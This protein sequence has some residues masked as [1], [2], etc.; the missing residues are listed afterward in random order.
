MNKDASITCVFGF[1][2]AGKTTYIKNEVKGCNALVVFD[3]VEEYAEPGKRGGV[4]QV[5]AREF[6]PTLRR[7]KTRN[8]RLAFTPKPGFERDNLDTLC[9]ILMQF[10][11]GYK[12]GIDKRQ[13]TL[14]VDEADV[15]YSHSTPA[16]HAFETVI[17]R[18]RHYGINVIAATQFPTQVKPDLRRNA[19]RTVI[20]PLSD[21]SAV[22]YVCQ[23]L[24]REY[25]DKV[26][27]LQP[28]HALIFEAGQVRNHKNPPPK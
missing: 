19:S 28:H 8:F 2:G 7:G 10:Q 3:P 6:V 21:N 24:G 18:G 20:F 16:G 14:V 25:G 15:A 26:R 22:T 12:E 23:F 17:R 5:T 13:V 27:G 9:R 11:L 1:R 4:K